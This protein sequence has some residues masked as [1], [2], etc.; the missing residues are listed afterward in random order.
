MLTT[1]CKNYY[2]QLDIITSPKPDLLSLTCIMI[3]FPCIKA[4]NIKHF[5]IMNTIGVS[6]HKIQ[7]TQISLILAI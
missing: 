3:Q 2:C 7:L 4:F 1:F 5:L 6:L